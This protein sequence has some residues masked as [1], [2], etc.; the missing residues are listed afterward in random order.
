MINPL[1]VAKAGAGKF[2]SVLGGLRNEKPVSTSKELALYQ[3]PKA[4]TARESWAPVGRALTWP[5]KSPARLAA[6]G[7][8]GIVGTR[9]LG[10]LETPEAP[11]A[12]ID[13]TQVYD[14]MRAAQETAAMQAALITGQVPQGQG[15]V[16]LLNQYAGRVPSAGGVSTPTSNVAARQAQAGI[17]SAALPTGTAVSG[18]TPVAGPV[19]TAADSL[20]RQG[21]TFNDYLNTL[22][23]FAR[24]SGVNLN[25]A[26]RERLR[27]EASKMYAQ[28]LD[29]VNKALSENATN[30]LKAQLDLGSIP[31]FIVDNSVISR[32]EALRQAGGNV[33][34]VEDYINL[35]SK[36]YYQ[37]YLGR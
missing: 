17:R 35:L 5:F 6:T 12:P 2:K 22:E 21:G 28:R 25:S 10:A 16:D 8:A 30:L 26:T 29:A 19:S 24:A 31:P 3:A 4:K 1:N 15:Y 33:R 20:I 36:Q 27:Q 32:A 13:L 11:A 34:P 18:V 14:P 9:A 23:Q 37:Q 7:L